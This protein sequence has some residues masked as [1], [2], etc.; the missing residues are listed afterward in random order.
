MIIFYDQ[1]L[2]EKFFFSKMNERNKLAWI[3]P[4]LSSRGYFLTLPGGRNL[5]K[6]YEMYAY[7]WLDNLISL[8]L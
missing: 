7:A 4:S 1:R 8:K 5:A 3:G 6:Q 2:F